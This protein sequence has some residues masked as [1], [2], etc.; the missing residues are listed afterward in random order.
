MKNSII[1]M[2]PATTD[3]IIVA[4]IGMMINPIAAW[5]SDARS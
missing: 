3:V 1:P 2:I 4:I 5:A